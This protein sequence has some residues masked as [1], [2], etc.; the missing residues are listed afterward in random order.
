MYSVV[1]KRRLGVPLGMSKSHP[2]FPSSN[3]YRP[4][5]AADALVRE[6]PDEDEDEEKDDS[7]EEDE[8]E[9]EDEGY[10]E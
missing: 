4:S 6:E 10:S 5:A 1:S 9:D 7:N 8:D 3:R 2:E